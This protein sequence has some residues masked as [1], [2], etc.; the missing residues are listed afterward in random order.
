MPT[1]ERITTPARI[2]SICTSRNRTEQHGR[3]SR[4]ARDMAPKAGA[5][6]C[7]RIPNYVPCRQLREQ[8]PRPGRWQ[9]EQPRRRAGAE[10]E[11]STTT[12]ATTAKAIDAA[13]APVPATATKATGFIN[14]RIDN[15]AVVGCVA[16]CV[17]PCLAEK[18]GHRLFKPTGTRR[19]WR[20]TH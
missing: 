19:T 5:H 12:A 13:K 10:Q 6:G 9:Q 17:R 1:R 15:E 18:M 8:S 20:T 2:R 3:H 16:M 11:N 7:T 4:W 14:H